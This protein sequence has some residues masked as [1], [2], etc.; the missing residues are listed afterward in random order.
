MSNPSETLVVCIIGFILLMALFALSL[1][2]AYLFSFR[3]PPGMTYRHTRQCSVARTLAALI[4]PVL[5]IAAGLFLLG[6]M[7][8]G[9]AL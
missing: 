1:T 5:V 9:G 6:Y 4:V 3:L 8:A 7:F 2:V